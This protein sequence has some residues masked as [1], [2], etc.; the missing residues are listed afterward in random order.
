MEG[1]ESLVNDV[2]QRKVLQETPIKMIGR[3]SQV[4]TRT[5][6]IVGKDRLGKKYPDG[7]KNVVDRQFRYGI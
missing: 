5:Q 4:Q 6:D 7:G 1:A 3:L 2:G